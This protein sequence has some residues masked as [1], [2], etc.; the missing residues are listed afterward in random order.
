[1]TLKELCS[2]FTHDVNIVIHD[3]TSGKA[4][5]DFVTVKKTVHESHAL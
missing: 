5:T 1:M 4:V 3:I 2:Q